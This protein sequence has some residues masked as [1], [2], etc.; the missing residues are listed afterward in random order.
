MT[1]KELKKKAKATG[2]QVIKRDDG[3]YKLFYKTIY[4]TSKWTLPEEILAIK[5]SIDDNTQ[6]VIIHGIVRKR[7]DIPKW[8]SRHVSFN[9]TKAF[10]RWLGDFHRI[11]L[12]QGNKIK[13]LKEQAHLPR[14]TKH[15]KARS[16]TYVSGLKCYLCN[17]PCI[18]AWTTWKKGS[19][20]T[21]SRKCMDAGM[22]YKNAIKHHKGK[23]WYTNP[24]FRK[25]RRGYVGAVRISPITGKKRRYL[26]H[27]YNW[28]LHYN[29]PVKK[30]N[31]LHHID[32]C[33]SSNDVTNLIECDPKEHQGM[34]YSFNLICKEL[35]ER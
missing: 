26:E 6:E 27:H 20:A 16:I 8:V 7:K 17:K 21:C 35:M 13:I 23:T 1:I 34:H 30:G 4:D 31:V 29:K 14:D 28:E 5:D 2:G 15:K 18:Q 32:M 11:M 3:N 22:E 12:R 10:K 25:N 9:S 19:K 24:K 33:K